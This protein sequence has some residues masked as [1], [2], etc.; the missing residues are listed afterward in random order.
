[1]K[2]IA[3]LFVIIFSLSAWVT[4]AIPIP[5]APADLSD[6]MQIPLQK[7]VT[8]HNGFTREFDG[9]YIKSECRY[10][11]VIKFKPY[12]LPLVF[13]NEEWVGPVVLIDDSG[14]YSSQALI[15][16]AKADML[17]QLKPGDRVTI[18]ARIEVHLIAVSLA[19]TIVYF[20]SPYLIINEITKS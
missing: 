17:L 3:P 1:M 19:S 7:A 12:N 11:S 14:H 8:Y 10:Y 20:Q 18:Y 4:P 5:T 16:R 13:K 15:P 6:Y 2:K 9:K